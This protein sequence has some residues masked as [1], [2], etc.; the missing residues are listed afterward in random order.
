ME[1]SGNGAG[2]GCLLFVIRETFSGIISTAALGNLKNDRGFDI[3]RRVE[4]FI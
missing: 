4:V 2:D 1:S 3:P